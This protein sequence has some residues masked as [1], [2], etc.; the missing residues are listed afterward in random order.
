MVNPPAVADARY[1]VFTRIEALAD[2]WTDTRLEGAVRRGELKRLTL[3][4]YRS[5]RPEAGASSVQDIDD[6]HRARAVAAA[7]AVPE[8]VISHAS[9]A[10]MHDLPVL[11]RPGRPC[12]T[13]RPRFTGDATCAHLYRAQ[14]PD[15][16]RDAR[17]GIPC[18]SVTRTVI[19]VAR[20]DGLMA[21]VVAADA[22]L[23]VATSITALKDCLDECARWPGIANARK[24]VVLAD[25]RS[26]SPLET[27]SRL[28][29][30]EIGFP[31]PALQ[32]IIRRQAGA[33]WPGSTSIGTSWAWSA[34]P[35]V[36]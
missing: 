30:A 29:L 9:A 17:R 26:E 19:D 8:S 23:G 10:L 6:E 20:H 34:R 27:L 7:L 24:A 14:L 15:H 1:G 21:G 22:A 13:V 3:G 5:V 4:V 32:T 25:A 31:T 28:R 33:S 11:R 35:M 18:T 36:D 16:H 2:G 12:I